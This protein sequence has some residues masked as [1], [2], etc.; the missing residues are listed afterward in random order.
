MDNWGTEETKKKKN[1]DIVTKILIV[2]MVL[3]LIIIIAIVLLVVVF[4]GV[5]VFPLL[6]S[7]LTNLFNAI[8]TFLKEISLD[9]IKFDKMYQKALDIVC[10]NDTEKEEK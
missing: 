6:F 9:S 7:Q 2:M 3:L 8:I 10:A 1:S 4:F 5:T